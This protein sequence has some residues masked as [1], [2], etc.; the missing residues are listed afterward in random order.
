MFIVV[1]EE[2]AHGWDAACRIHVVKVYNDRDGMEQRAGS[3]TAHWY[4]NAELKIVYEIPL[5]IDC[6]RIRCEYAFV[7][8]K[9]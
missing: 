5:G 9:S 6:R 4:K 7:H 3:I 1:S 8:Q 2:S